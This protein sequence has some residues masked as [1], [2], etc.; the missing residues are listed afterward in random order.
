LQ[1]GNICGGKQEFTGFAQ[2]AD[3]AKGVEIFGEDE[4]ERDDGG[5]IT[6][7][8]FFSLWKSLLPDRTIT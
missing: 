6:V 2:R 4:L 5:N 1:Q 3:R 7:A 8:G